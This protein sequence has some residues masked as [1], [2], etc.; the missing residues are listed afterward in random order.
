MVWV[1]K[2]PLIAHRGLH[3]NGVAEN[4]LNSFELAIKHGYAIELD[5]QFLDNGEPIVFHDDNFIRMTGEN[6]TIAHLNPRFL[7]YLT[8]P[9]GQ[10]ILTLSEVLK[11]VE[12]K[13]P[14]L[15][16][17]KNDSFSKNGLNHLI[18]LLTSYRG[19]F[20]IQSFN[21]KIIS[22]IKAKAPH[23]SVGQLTTKWEQTELSWWKKKILRH[24]EF[25]NDVD[26]LAVDQLKLGQKERFI[27]KTKKIPL[28]CWTIRSPQEYQK[29]KNICDGFIFEGFLP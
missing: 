2:Y 28:L 1:E 29:M 12:G 24:V 6:C 19:K 27:S 4:S 11:V 15:I 14:L 21:P 22:L 13:V 20:S 8:Y 26:F 3:G 7:K 9:D 16:E 18:K 10:K 25:Y 17:I 23:F 5:I